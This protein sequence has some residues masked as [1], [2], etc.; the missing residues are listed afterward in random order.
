[1]FYTFPAK[2]LEQSHGLNK[3]FFSFQTCAETSAIYKICL[4]TTLEITSGVKQNKTP[5]TYLL[6]KVA[7]VIAVVSTHN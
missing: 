4:D 1:V 6:I 7:K 2:F 3:H 5:S